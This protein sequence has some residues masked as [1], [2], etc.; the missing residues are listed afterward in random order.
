[1]TPIIIDSRFTARQACCRA[2]IA[3]ATSSLLRKQSLSPS[4]CARAWATMGVVEW[5]NSSSISIYRLLELNM[6]CDCVVAVLV[7]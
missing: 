4:T 2:R 3:F 7:W 6:R 5:Q 1:M